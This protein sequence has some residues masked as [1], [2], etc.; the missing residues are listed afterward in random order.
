M[1]LKFI[2]H[3]L[4][5]RVVLDS[6]KNLQCCKANETVQVQCISLSVRHIDSFMQKL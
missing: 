3:D 1:S 4:A 6:D 5:Y 2:L